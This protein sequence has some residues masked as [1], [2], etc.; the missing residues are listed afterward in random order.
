MLAIIGRQ[1]K[2]LFYCRSNRLISVESNMTDNILGTRWISEEA[3]TPVSDTRR[4]LLGGRLGDSRD[5]PLGG[6]NQEDRSSS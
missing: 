6:A 2:L 4:A 3:K 1:F 5:R